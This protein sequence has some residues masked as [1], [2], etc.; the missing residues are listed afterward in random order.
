MSAH[1]YTPIVRS[2]WATHA[3]PVLVVSLCLRQPL[4]NRR[5]RAVRLVGAISN[6]CLKTVRPEPGEG[7]DVNGT[8]AT[9]A[10]HVHTTI[11]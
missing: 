5:I 8:R 9:H 7:C 2:V 6:L 1:G 3:S 10:S 4:C 11:Q